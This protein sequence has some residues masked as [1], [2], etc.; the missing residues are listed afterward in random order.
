MVLGQAVFRTYNQLIAFK[1]ISLAWYMPKGLIFTLDIASFNNGGGFCSMHDGFLSNQMA[2]RSFL[3]NVISSYCSD[4][5]FLW[6]S[7]VLQKSGIYSFCEASL[8]KARYIF[9][10]MDCATKTI[11]LHGNQLHF[12]ECRLLECVLGSVEKLFWSPPLKRHMSER[13]LFFFPKLSWV[14]NEPL[15]ISHTD[16]VIHQQNKA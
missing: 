8:D 10:R 3:C 5:S 6:Q 12:Y 15:P 1:R 7:V 2:E 14:N 13:F 16:K 11:G 4:V 9:R